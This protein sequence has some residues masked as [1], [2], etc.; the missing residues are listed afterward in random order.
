MKPDLTWGSDGFNFKCHL[1]QKPFTNTINDLHPLCLASSMS[2]SPR[3]TLC[4]IIYYITLKLS[5]LYQLK[6]KDFNIAFCRFNGCNRLI[7]IL[8]RKYFLELTYPLNNHKNVRWILLL[9][10]EISKLRNTK[11]PLWTSFT[12]KEST[13]LYPLTS[14]KQKHLQGRGKPV[15]QCDKK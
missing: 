1:F 8:S 14:D 12:L 9:L 10:E 2:E 13:W 6:H 7:T 15:S 11:E 5:K 3:P 4:P